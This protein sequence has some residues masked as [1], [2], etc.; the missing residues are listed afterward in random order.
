MA[1]LPLHL[2]PPKPSLPLCPTDAPRHL[3][4]VS[5]S[6]AMRFSMMARTVM[7]F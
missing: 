2:I 7:S 5:V 1:T 6:V 3:T 4:C